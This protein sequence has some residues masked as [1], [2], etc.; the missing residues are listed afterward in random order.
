MVAVR[1]IPLRTLWVGY[2][3]FYLAVLNTFLFEHF[4]TFVSKFLE[5]FSQFLQ[6]PS[7]RPRDPG[8]SVGFSLAVATAHAKIVVFVFVPNSS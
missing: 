3:G 6:A 8:G 1:N 4:P 5:M 7:P 2:S